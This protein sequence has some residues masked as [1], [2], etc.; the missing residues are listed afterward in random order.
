MFELTIGISMLTMLMII[1]FL[2]NAYEIH[3]LQKKIDSL[4]TDLQ[5]KTLDDTCDMCFKDIAPNKDRHTVSR[6]R[7]S[8][9]ICDNCFH[10]LWE[11]KNV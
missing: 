7:A 4:R 5:I 3:E 6:E 8:I 10:S 2:C 1:L 11:R 9:T